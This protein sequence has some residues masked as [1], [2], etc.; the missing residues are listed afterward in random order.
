M[1][2]AGPG[3]SM[4]SVRSTSIRGPE[5]MRASRRR[6]CAL[7]LHGHLLGGA[8]EAFDA[9]ADLHLRVKLLAVEADRAAG[10]QPVRS[11]WQLRDAAGQGGLDAVSRAAH[12]RESATAAANE[13]TSS[14][15]VS[16]EHIQRTTPASSSQT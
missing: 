4:S 5:K 9:Q 2:P 7:S 13:S 16:H 11:A 3:I 6:S 15:V 12:R 1:A 14:A 8:E 10:K